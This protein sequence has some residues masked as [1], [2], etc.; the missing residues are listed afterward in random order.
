MHEE[1]F[2]RKVMKPRDLVCYQVQHRETDLFC[3]TRTDLHDVVLDRVLIYRRQLDQYIQ[4]RP[5]FKGSLSPI[6]IDSLAPP[7]AKEM[8]TV[9]TE[10]GVGPMATVAGAFAEFTGRDIAAKSVTFIIENGGD[11]CLKTNVER[12]VQIYANNSPFS[13]TIGI[14]LKPKDFPYGVCTSSATV[15]PSLSLG[16]ADAVCTIAAS[17][18][19]ADG[20]ATYLG[21]IVKKKED[22]P[23][24]IEK[25]QGFAGVIG[26]L[27]ILGKH[28]GL[29]GDIEI[30]Q[31]N[32]LQQ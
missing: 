4:Y 25:G 16:R 18:L 24:A 29:W 12:I 31:L 14:K 5:E 19:F 32:G 6:P 15:G 28:L 22:I 26:I 17:A 8:I 21:N 10:L 11:I 9:S 27:I 7:I 13:G 23:I 30:V 1:R 2:Y 3:C 20:L